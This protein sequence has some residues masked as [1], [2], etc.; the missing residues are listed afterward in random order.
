MNPDYKRNKRHRLFTSIRFAFWG[1][2]KAIKKERNIKIHLG[3]MTLA[4][5]MGLVLKI[6]NLEWIVLVILFGLV[7]GGEIFNSAIEASADLIRDRMELDYYETYWVRN[8]AAGAVMVFAL[9]ALVVGLL[10]FLPKIF[11]GQ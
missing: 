10:I 6:S 4:T 2:W 8:L 11:G 5:I 1:I 3:M 7:I 9:A